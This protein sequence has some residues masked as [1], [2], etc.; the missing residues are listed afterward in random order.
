MRSDIKGGCIFCGNK[1]NLSKQHMWPNWLAKVLPRITTSHSNTKLN[2]FR[3]AENIVVAP[4]FKKHQGHIGGKK[5]RI[6]CEDCNGGWMSKLE[7]KAKPILTAIFVDKNLIITIEDQFILCS[8]ILMTAM[9]AEF[10]DIETVSIPFKYRSMLI[11]G[12]IAND[13]KIWIGR[14][15]GEGVAWEQR[16]FHYGFLFV[17]PS[18]YHNNK[19]VELSP[20]TQ[21]STLC[22]GGIFIHVLSSLMSGVNFEFNEYINLRMIQI[23]PLNDESIKLSNLEVI[24]NQDADMIKDYFGLPLAIGKN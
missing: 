19:D 24:N 6:V 5:L 12:N 3:E 8:W 13:F 20:N 23:L 21:F 22:V 9:V 17:N 18:E 1:N 10:S 11:D 4:Y 15:E 16:Y 2:Y 14:Y 7:Q